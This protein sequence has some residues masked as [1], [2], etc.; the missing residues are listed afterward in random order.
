MNREVVNFLIQAGILLSYIP[1]T[2]LA[3][4]GLREPHKQLHTEWELSLFG[5]EAKAN[6]ENSLAGDVY[7]SLREYIVPLTY[8]FTVMMALYAMTH[9][10]IINLGLWDGLLEGMVNV[11]NLPANGV[12]AEIIT[13]RFMFWTWLGAYV[14]S[15]DRTVRHYLAQDLNPN[16]YIYAARRFLF[17]FIIGS[18]VGLGVGSLGQTAGLSFDQNLTTVYII[19]FSIGLFPERGIRWISATTNRVLNQKSAKEQRSLTLIDGIGEWQQGR[20]D[21]EGISNVENLAMVNLLALVVKTPF[22][23]GQVVHWV[24]QAILITEVS[25][26]Q[27]EKFKKIGLETASNVLHAV[28]NPQLCTACKM[29]GSELQL[30]NLTLRAHFNL[31]L[32]LRFHENAREM[33]VE[34][35]QPVASLAPEGAP[36]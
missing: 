20:L 14:H 25:P 10:A 35:V 15:V 3:Y 7:Y 4:R 19:C 26:G 17:A 23:V 8:I 18:I 30:I 9:P 12:R 22:D 33:G 2:F 21:Q 11:F 29:S 24:D 13:G 28:E 16:V 6:Y 34:R 5:D 32:I 1:I 31:K 27:L 36:G